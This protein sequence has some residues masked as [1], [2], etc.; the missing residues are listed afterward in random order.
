MSGIESVTMYERNSHES[1]IGFSLGLS[2]GWRGDI[3]IETG[4]GVVD[5]SDAS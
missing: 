3:S 2:R 1:F 5:K 4:V